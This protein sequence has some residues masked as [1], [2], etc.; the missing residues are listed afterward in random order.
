[1]EK[2]THEEKIRFYAKLAKEHLDLM[3][4]ECKDCSL[5][6]ASSIIAMGEMQAQA[7]DEIF[8]AIGMADA[9]YEEAKQ[10]I[11]EKFSEGE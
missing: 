6:F 1:M 5:K 2:L 7:I 9:T 3:S 4:K 10:A 8:T 11:I